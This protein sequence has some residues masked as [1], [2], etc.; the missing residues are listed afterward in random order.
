LTAA[1]RNGNGRF[2]FS[3]DGTS[4]FNFG[5]FLAGNTYELSVK[6]NISTVG[7]SYAQRMSLSLAD[8]SNVAV[9]SADIGLQI[10]TD[11]AGGLAVF[12]RVDAVSNPGGSSSNTSLTNGLPI[13]TPITL[14]LRITDYN[15]DVTA[16]NSSYTILVNG[17]TNNTGMFRFNNSTT[18]RYLVFDVAAHEGDVYYDNLQLTVTAGGG[19]GST[20]IKHELSLADVNSNGAGGANIR[21]FWTAQPGLTVNP[22]MSTDLSTWLPMTNS[23]GNPL[24]ITTPH[25]TIQWLEVA[26]PA[27]TNQGAFIRLRQE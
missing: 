27:T 4:G 7:T 25:G 5:N 15:A 10:G 20:C 6:M 19:T 24:S 16:Y 1:P 21:L 8:V 3:A 18:A 14:T 23:S 2:E 9:G 26:S 11:G 13:G 22:E 17:A 12:K